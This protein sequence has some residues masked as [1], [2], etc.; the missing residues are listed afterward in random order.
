MALLKL[1]IRTFCE[2]SHSYFFYFLFLFF[3]ASV[4]FIA[5]SL[6]MRLY[7]A[8]EAV[9]LNNHARLYPGDSPVDIRASIITCGSAVSLLSRSGGEPWPAALANAA[10]LQ[11]CA[12]RFQRRNPRGNC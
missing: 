10:S 4:K 7:I 6:W 3:V 1:Q 5:F 2:F 11:H 12:S 8:S 9:V